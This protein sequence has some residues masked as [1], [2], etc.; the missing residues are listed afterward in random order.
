[1]SHKRIHVRVPVSGVAI[2]A[3]HNK[4]RL[5]TEILDISQGGIAVSSPSIPLANEIYDITVD[6]ENA[7]K[8]EFSAEL[9]RQDANILAFKISTIDDT[10]LQRIQ[11]L[12]FAYQETDEF[13]DQLLEHNLLDHWFQDEDG[14]EIEIAFY[15]DLKHD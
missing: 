11:Q 9:I 6:I 1:M 3:N 14:N 2:M 15:S 7:I 13:I 4:I 12:V 5:S 10:N 8:I